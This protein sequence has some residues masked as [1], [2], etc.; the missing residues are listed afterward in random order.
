MSFTL[1]QLAERVGATLI[2]DGDVVV[3]GCA[4]I[5]AAGPSELTFLANARYAQFLA[6]TKAAGVLI[7]PQ[8]PCP[9]HLNRLVSDNPYFAFR[10]ALIELHGFR[11]HPPPIDELVS[12]DASKSESRISRH[13]AVHPEAII[14]SGAAIH[15][16]VVV[17]AGARVGGNTVLYP[18]VYLGPDVIVGENCVLHPNVSVYERCV[19]GDRVTI[20]SST[21]IGQ[22]GFGYA[23]HEGAHHKIPQ[24]GIVVIEDDVELGG[25]CAI[26]RAA[27]GETR[28]GKG[29][30]F[31]DLISIGHGTRIGE[32][33]L[34][35]SLVGIS[36]SV[37]VGNYVV[38]GG[39]VGVAGHLS[40]G[41]GVQAA[42][43]AAITGD[44]PPGKKVAGVPAIDLDRAKRN[45]LAG[46]DLY[47]LVKRVR[48]LE[49]E[50][51]KLRE[52]GRDGT[53]DERG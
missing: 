43:K 9:D 1:R 44:I 30:K 10:N 40:I 19:I 29:T 48:A 52:R 38:L 23:T 6:S 8:T 49:R 15:P 51:E 2:G 53:A 13:A 12:T 50:I 32:H 36:G 7:D 27:M 14:E 28:I 34:L 17:E 47:G 39:Q 3:T 46:Q 42:G 35:V 18:G 33:C 21:V 22:D 25:G 24:T 31:A 37:E 4:P 11:A 26:E 20:H 45:A 16:F 41:D 5:E